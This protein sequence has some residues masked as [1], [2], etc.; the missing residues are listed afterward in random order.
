MGREALKAGLRRVVID[1]SSG[2]YYP[3]NRAKLEADTLTLD[4]DP[5]SNAQDVDPRT[6]RP[7]KA[8]ETGL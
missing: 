7:I 6:K 3:D 8:L 4:H 5:I 1:N 2:N